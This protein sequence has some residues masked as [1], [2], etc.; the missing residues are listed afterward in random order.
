M[1]FTFLNQLSF[2]TPQLRDFI[3]HTGK[4]RALDC[5]CIFFDH[6]YV[7]VEPCRTVTLRILCKPSDWQ[8]SSLSQ[9]YNSALSPL[10]TLEHLEIYNH[11]E[12]W[13]DDM[14]NIQWLEFLR[15]FPSVKNLVLSVKSLR[16]V[17]PALNELDGESVTEVLPALR[18]IVIQGP[19]SSEVDNKSV[20]KF[21]ATR[22][23]L[24]SPVTIQHRDGKALDVRGY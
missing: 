22:Q 23:L 9:L 15:L 2:D 1:N 13:E 19:Q 24:G 10:P 6:G 21:T 7:T 20:G 18:I 5:A 11:R 16:L 4:F 17:A 3:R 8:L 14:E 12:Y